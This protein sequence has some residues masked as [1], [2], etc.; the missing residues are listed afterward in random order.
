MVRCTALHGGAWLQERIA[1]LPPDVRQKLEEK[2]TRQA[3][4]KAY[5]SK[6]GQA[7]R[8]APAMHAACIGT[9]HGC[10][11]PSPWAWGERTPLRQGHNAWHM[12]PMLCS[13][14]D[15]SLGSR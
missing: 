15:C 8:Q 6:V 9:Q 11:V 4:K 14:N 13:G 12:G 1:K 3:A 5:R 10:L 2:Q 7:G